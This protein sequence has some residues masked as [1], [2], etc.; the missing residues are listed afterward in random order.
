MTFWKSMEEKSEH[1][2][3]TRLCMHMWEGTGIEN[4][5]KKSSFLIFPS[6]SAMG[7]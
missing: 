4:E 7:G 5:N 1:F 6:I 2:D 3:I